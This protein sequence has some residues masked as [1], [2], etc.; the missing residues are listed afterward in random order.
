MTIMC[1]PPPEISEREFKENLIAHIRDSFNNDFSESINPQ[2]FQIK[3]EIIFCHEEADKFESKLSEFRSSGKREPN[4]VESKILMDQTE[5]LYD[6]YIREQKLRALAEMKIIFLYKNLEIT[7][8]KFLEIAYSMD[9]A[10]EL[11]NWDDIKNSFKAKNVYLSEFEEYDDII[12]L[13]QVSNNL[14]HSE[15]IH[16]NVKSLSEFKSKS[17]FEFQDLENFYSR[18]EMNVF[19]FIFSLSDK[20]LQNVAS[21]T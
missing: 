18:I 7:L 14:K 3:D 2:I 16:E 15:K 12:E 19:S 8:K 11:F 6:A 1:E 10:K 17:I 20:L 21:G 5:F 9:E 13:K 4:E